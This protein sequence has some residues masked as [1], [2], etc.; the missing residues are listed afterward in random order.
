MPVFSIFGSHPRG[1]RDPTCTIW[2]LGIQQVSRMKWGPVAWMSVLQSFDRE[3]MESPWNQ[4]AVG[5]ACSWKSTDK[6]ESIPVPTMNLFQSR[7][8]ACPGESVSS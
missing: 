1:H 2:S 4:C 7:D 8:R 5:I 3:R 6:I